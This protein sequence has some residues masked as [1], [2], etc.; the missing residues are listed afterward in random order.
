[1]SARAPVPD[2]DWISAHSRTIV[3]HLGPCGRIL[4]L[5]CGRGRD[6]ALLAALAPVVAIDVDDQALLACRQR[7]PAA[8]LVRADLSRPLPL[9]SASFQVVVASLAIHYFPW[10]TT[11]LL[12][13]EIRRCMAPGGV[14]VLRVNSTRDQYYGATS[15]DQI[16]PN[17]VWVE[18][19]PKRFFDRETTLRL[20]RHW[21]VESVQEKAILRY[22]QPKHVWEA[23]FR[24]V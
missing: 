20:F 22:R 19:Q 15:P 7:V 24:L 17:F 12:A 10:Q 21:T 9:P 2:D 16:E 11:E 8:T 6:T 3:R 1:M 23:V 18:G 14:L 5:G 4:E 13:E